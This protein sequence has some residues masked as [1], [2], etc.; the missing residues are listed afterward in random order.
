MFWKSEC[1]LWR[2]AQC[3]L[4]MVKPFKISLSVLDMI[5]NMH[6]DD[7]YFCVSKRDCGRSGALWVCL[8][9]KG[10]GLQGIYY[11]GT[12]GIKNRPNN[13]QYRG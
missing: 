12:I 1:A 6:W 10:L 9:V 8:S 4:A 3:Y 13:T 2:P 7:N 5:G 11:Q